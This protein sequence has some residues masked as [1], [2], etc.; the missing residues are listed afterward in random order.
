MTG[1]FGG[2]G[3]AMVQFTDS[4]TNCPKCG[5]PAQIGDGTYR[6][7]DEAL[8]LVAGPPMTWDMIAALKGV[9]DEAKKHS[10]TTD[11]ILASI[12]DISPELA[13]TL[14]SKFALPAFALILLL[15]WLIKSVELNVTVDLNR[16]ID[17][18]WSVANDVPLVQQES[19]DTDALEIPDDAIVPADPIQPNPLTIAALPSNEG[20]RLAPMPNRK[21]RRQAAARSRKRGSQA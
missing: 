8:T 19:F 1:L 3:I 20:D 6:L 21:A 18:A 14:K 10:S 17:Q 7:E 16:L 4:K 5:G 15:I 11:D 13:A 9:V 2:A 12:A